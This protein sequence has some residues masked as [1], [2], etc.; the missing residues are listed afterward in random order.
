[1][2]NVLRAEDMTM[3]TIKH[4]CIAAGTIVALSTNMV[5]EKTYCIVES[6]EPNKICFMKYVNGVRWH[7]SFSASDVLEYDLKI[8]VL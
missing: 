1:M 5:D 2:S 3:V 8:D 6:V 4:R 7:V